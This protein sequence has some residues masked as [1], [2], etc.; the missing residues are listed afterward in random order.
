MALFSL[1]MDGENC[2]GY[3]TY[4]VEV[5]DDGWLLNSWINYTHQESFWQYPLLTAEQ[6]EKQ[7]LW[8][9]TGGFRTAQSAIQFYPHWTSEETKEDPA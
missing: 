5:L 6:H 8:N 2:R 4:E 3:L 9:G 7:G 1:P